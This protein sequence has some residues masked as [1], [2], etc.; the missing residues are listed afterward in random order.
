MHGAD[1]EKRT[2]ITIQEDRTSTRFQFI[3][4]EELENENKGKY[5]AKR[6]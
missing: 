1:E 3:T 2:W 4:N 5:D 6:G